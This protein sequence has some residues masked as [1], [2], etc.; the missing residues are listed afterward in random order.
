MY[1]YYVKTKDGELYHSAYGELYH[2][3]ILG[4]KWGVRRYQNPDGSLT[5]EGMR[6]YRKGEDGKYHKRS[7]IERIKYDKE[8]SNA[9]KHAA[10]SFFENKNN[11]ET[12]KA[13]NKAQ[14]KVDKHMTDKVA[15]IC[16]DLCKMNNIRSVNDPKYLDV[17]YQAWQVSEKALTND[18]K[19]NKLV[20]NQEILSDSID[21]IIDNM[22]RNLGAN[23]RLDCNI[24]IWNKISDK[25]KSYKYQY[26]NEVIKNMSELTLLQLME[27]DIDRIYK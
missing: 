24:A 2:F 26:P 21:S 9:K 6:R 22:Y 1:T 23:S 7:A 3:G 15:S 13:Y 4:M 12:A 5:E 8:L 20:K 18:K 14:Y 11:K 25:S 16:E 19:F 27:A 10:K 17:F